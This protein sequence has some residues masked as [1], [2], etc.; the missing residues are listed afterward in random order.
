MDVASDVM[1]SPPQVL[2]L[3]R[4]Q[5][6]GATI[7]RLSKDTKSSPYAKMVCT[8]I[9]QNLMGYGRARCATTESVGP[10]GKL[11]KWEGVAKANTSP[12]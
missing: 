12:K 11:S 7:A 10:M 8:A 2:T 4:S 9:D 1:E 3:V 6:T 5:S